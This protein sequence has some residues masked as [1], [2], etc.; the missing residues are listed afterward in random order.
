[1]D[2]SNTPK[3]SGPVN[4]DDNAS[5]IKN[6]LEKLEQ[7]HAVPINARESIKMR[8]IDMEFRKYEEEKNKKSTN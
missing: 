3:K 8:I 2:K 5:Y 6:K 1:M 4:T 7:Y